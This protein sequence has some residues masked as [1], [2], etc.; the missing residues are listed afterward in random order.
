MCT[1][2]GVFCARNV[3]NS[4]RWESR[5][6]LHRV[7]IPSPD[8]NNRDRSTASPAM[9]GWTPTLKAQVLWSLNSVTKHQSYQSNEGVGHLFRVVFTDSDIVHSFACGSDQ[10]A[11]ISRFGLAPYIS[12]QLVADAN[13]VAF[14]LMFG[15]SLNQT[16]KTKQLD[17]HIRCWCEDHVQS[18]Y[19]GSQL[20]GHGTAEDLL[21][22]FKEGA[23]DLDRRKLL[24]IS[25]DG[26]NVNWKFLELLQQEHTAT[27][28]I[29]PG[30]VVKEKKT[31]V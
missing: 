18:R 8:S 9:F 25:M 5:P 16:T 28:G 20:M 11:Y 21:R 2:R 14:V 19:S 4:A 30:G 12:E 10:T 7:S 22:H 3:S 31:F 17:L 27:E 24:S 1:R 13:K 23:K 15:E 29:L 26:P 6:R